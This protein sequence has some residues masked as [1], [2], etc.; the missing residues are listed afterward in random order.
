MRIVLKDFSAAP[1]DDLTRSFTILYGSALHNLNI[2]ASAADPRF[3]QTV[4]GLRQELI[5]LQQRFDELVREQKILGYDDNSGLRA[6]LRDSGNAVERIINENTNWLDA[7]YAQRLMIALLTMRD[8]CSL[9]R[10]TT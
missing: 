1:D 8:S 5:K 2:I 9:Q 3:G 6:K 4:E 10:K 7:S